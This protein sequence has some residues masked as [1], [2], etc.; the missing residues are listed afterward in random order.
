MCAGGRQ[1]APRGLR[2]APAYVVERLRERIRER[3]L[4]PCR[5][6]DYAGVLVAL[7]WATSAP[8]TAANGSVFART[9]ISHLMSI[10]GLHVTMVAALGAWL[11]SFASGGAGRR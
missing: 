11:V 5:N 1:P 9:G 7:A 4:A 3:F 10:S 2:L 6:A 8:S